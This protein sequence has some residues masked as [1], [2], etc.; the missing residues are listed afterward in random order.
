M[1]Y[2]FGR[3]NHP[4]YVDLIVDNPYWN[5][6]GPVYYQHLTLPTLCSV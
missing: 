6:L 4:P 1:S 5:D 2:T 3:I